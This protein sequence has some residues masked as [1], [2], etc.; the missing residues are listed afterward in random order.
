MSRP[1]LYTAAL[2]ERIL[3]ELRSGRTLEEVCQDEAMPCETTVYKWV[4]EDVDGFAAR[5][6]RARQAGVF[7]APGQVRYSREI[8]DL[9][10]DGLACGRH[11]ADICKDAGMPSTNTIA[12]WVAEDRDGFAGRY[13]LARQIGHGR[14]GQI[15]Y[16]KEIEDVILGELMCGRTLTDVCRDPDMPHL[17]SV[18][19]WIEQDREGFAARY[20]KA[21]EIGCETMADDMVDIADDRSGDWI[22]KTN[23]DGT[24][25]AFL[26]PERVNRNRLRIEA[27][28]GRLS[29]ALARIRADRLDPTAKPD[30][31]ESWADL[32]KAVDGKS[33]GWPNKGRKS[34]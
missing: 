4:Q 20:R 13:R 9:V 23:R 26:D 8:A 16:S 33:W 6:R 30:S 12:C 18:H 25:V 15:P 24:T 1:P 5:Y 28:R 32:L 22:V 3:S 11:L 17:R 29:K 19:K 21:L 14:T 31:G 2:A 27:R 34:E 7:I 10:T